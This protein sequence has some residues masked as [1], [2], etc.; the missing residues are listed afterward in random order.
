MA[1]A[2]DL[3]ITG[4]A[5]YFEPL[6]PAREYARRGQELDAAAKEA[7]EAGSPNAEQLDRDAIETLVNAF[8]VDRTGQSACFSEAHRVGREVNAQYGCPLRHDDQGA[9]VVE[10]GIL[11]LHS[12]IGL[13]VAGV[14]RGRCSICG[15]ADLHCLH[16]PGTV[17]DGIRCIREV[18]EQDLREISLVPLPD[19]PR[20][21]RVEAP[22]S[23]ADVV[24]ARGRALLPGEVPTCTHCTTC[25]GAPTAEDLDPTLWEKRAPRLEARS[26]GDDPN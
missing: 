24:R 17:Y 18:Y 7:R 15:A 11:A 12:R 16:V 5:V 8:L 1:I 26:R 9:W 4:R 6:L 21:Y 19:D 22:V 23:D 10:C 14:S 3:H 25:T 20:T 13:S 2:D